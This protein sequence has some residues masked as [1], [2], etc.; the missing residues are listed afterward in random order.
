MDRRPVTGSWK[1]APPHDA[2]TQGLVVSG[3]ADLP[4][5]RALM[6]DFQWEGIGSGA[7]LAA[8]ETIAPVTNAGGKEAR[9]T[10]LAFAHAGLTKMGLAHAALDSFAAPFREGMMQEDRLRRLGDRRNGEWQETVIPDGPRW[11][12]N[13]AQRGPMKSAAGV[14]HKAKTATGHQE[15]PITTAL[16]VHALL[17]LYDA[18]E[19]KVEQWAA[20]VEA[21]LT[22]H[23]IAIVHTLPLFLRLDEKGIAREHFGFADGVSQPVPFDAA[24]VVPPDKDTMHG[25][26]LG[27]VLLGFVNSH[28]ELPPTPMA[29]P[30]EKA[31]DAGLRPHPL[32]DGFL[33]LGF[34]GSYIVVRELKQNVAAF[35]N[36]LDAGADHIRQRDPTNSAHVTADWLAERAVGRDQDGALLCPK[37]T[38]VAS[39]DNAFG[40]FDRD[41]HG[42]GCPVGSHVRRANPRDGLAPDK[43]QKETLLQAANNHRIL[44]RGRKYGTTIADPRTDD[45]VDRGLLFICLN[46]D[47]GRQFEFVQ[48]T[49]LLNHNFAT[50]YDETDPLLGPKGTMT[51]RDGVLRRR[52][53]VETYIQMVGGDYFFLPSMAALRYLAALPSP[54]HIDD[55]GMEAVPPD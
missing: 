26:P 14:A 10:A 25:I 18:T 11:S 7:W 43:S 39:G 1:L 3:F 55:E 27:D 41:R 48:Q 33:D 6:L 52:V 9:A 5:G 38:L 47:I 8:L 45:G 34:E 32:A 49:W 35:W 21:M 17:L 31:A 42:H 2:A 15:E 16:T 4:T 44:R 54:G 13:T 24:A 19:D 36:S 46:T 40:F 20:E 12:A 30:L 51:V 37:G 22:A 28:H 50:L 53:D 23:Q 29:P